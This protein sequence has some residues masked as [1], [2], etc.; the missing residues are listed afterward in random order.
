VH[1]KGKEPQGRSRA[2]AMPVLRGGDEVFYRGVVCRF[3][4]LWIEGWSGD[5]QAG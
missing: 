3:F 4:H 2:K 5:A 1:C